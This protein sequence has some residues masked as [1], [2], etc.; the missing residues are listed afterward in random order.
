MK[1][2]D[3]NFD[4]DQGVREPKPNPGTITPAS[5]HPAPPPP[6]PPAPIPYGGPYGIKSR[7]NVVIG[8]SC[9]GEITQYVVIGHANLTEEQR[10]RFLRNPKKASVELWTAGE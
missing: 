9:P 6:P 1:Q 3:H 5:Q 4:F 2:Q 8:V 7:Y 10:A